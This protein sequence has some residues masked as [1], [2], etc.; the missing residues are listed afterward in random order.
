LI[1]YHIT[2]NIDIINI[3]SICIVEFNAIKSPYHHAAIEI[4]N[5]IV[6]IVISQSNNGDNRSFIDENENKIYNAININQTITAVKAD[7]L[8]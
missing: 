3:V 7:F 5:N 1:L 4:S 2:V 8:I 6:N